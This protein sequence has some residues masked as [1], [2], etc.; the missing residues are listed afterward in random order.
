[1]KKG[2][3]KA[4]KK[5]L[6]HGGR[7]RPAT[8]CSAACRQKAYRKRCADQHAAPLRLLRSHLYAVAD[9]EARKRAAVDVLTE[10]GFAVEL[11]PVGVAEG[12]YCLETN[13]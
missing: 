4:C 7:G 6:A 10:L 11:K 2:R 1:M 12:Q 13:A 3:C 8:Y 5:P 9:R